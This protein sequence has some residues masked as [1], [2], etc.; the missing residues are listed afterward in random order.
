MNQYDEKIARRLSLLA[1]GAT[2]LLFL[3]GLLICRYSFVGNRLAY[4]N[5]NFAGMIIMLILPSS[6][7]LTANVFCGLDL[8]GPLK[9]SQEMYDGI[10]PFLAPAA[11]L[12]MLYSGKGSLMPPEY[13]FFFM[14][15]WILGIFLTDGINYR[16]KRA[17][18]KDKDNERPETVISEL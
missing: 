5:A 4:P 2:L 10:V 11:L 15:A 7:A 12:G 14:L 13:V 3:S 16:L 17:C 6:A 8:I 9:Y 18:R 1:S